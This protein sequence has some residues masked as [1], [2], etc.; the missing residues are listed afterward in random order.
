LA[1]GLFDFCAIMHNGNSNRARPRVILGN[2]LMRVEKLK[3]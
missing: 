3:G 1:A 2:I